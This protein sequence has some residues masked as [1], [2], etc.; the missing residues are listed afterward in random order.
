LAFNKHQHKKKNRIQNTLNITN[1]NESTFSTAK[2]KLYS[3]EISKIKSNPY[4]PRFELDNL[5]DL[6]DSIKEFGLLQPPTVSKDA[7]NDKYILIYGHRRLEAVKELGYESIDVFIQDN[8]D[9]NLRL[10]ALAENSQ[11]Q[12]LDFLELAYAY[13]SIL[14]DINISLEDLGKKV[15][16]SK[17]YIS[18]VL[19][20]LKL[21]SEVIAQ[22]KKDG[23]KVLSVLNKLNQIDKENQL[24]LYNQIK[25]LTRDDALSILSQHL[26]QK[27][28]N[29]SKYSFKEK[30]GKY[31]FSIDTKNISKDEIQQA[32]SDLL[33]TVDKL[34]DL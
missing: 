23:Y 20:I 28:K 16:K 3:I 26:N 8:N 22:T 5:E 19:S 17:T 33:A 10:K 34:K 11:R 29:N 31:N 2:N 27:S 14:E 7:S 18:Q 25:S 13:K 1:S 4:Q 30:S 32:I 24:D 9:L 15:N 6:K 21:E 12:D